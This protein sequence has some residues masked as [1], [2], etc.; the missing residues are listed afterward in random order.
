MASPSLE[1]SYN[2]TLPPHHCLVDVLSCCFVP[3]SV[4][5]YLVHGHIAIITETKSMYVMIMSTLQFGDVG[6]VPGLLLL[7]LVCFKDQVCIN[8]AEWETD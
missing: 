2:S 8:K 5:S 7:F 4:N 1:F 3:L 6:V